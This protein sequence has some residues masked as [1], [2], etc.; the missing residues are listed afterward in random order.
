MSELTQLLESTTINSDL[1]VQLEQH[2]AVS[3][4]EDCK[5]VSEEVAV[6]VNAEHDYSSGGGVGRKSILTVFRKDKKQRQSWQYSDKWSASR[7]RRDL[8]I[9]SVGKV[10]ILH[11]SGQVQIQ[12][13]CVAPQGHSPRKV[14]FTFKNEEGADSR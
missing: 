11:G 3:C 14:T 1:R 9:L 4:L 8:M 5:L 12:V 10:E 2:K 6:A 7:D 13:E